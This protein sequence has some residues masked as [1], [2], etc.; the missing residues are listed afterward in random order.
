M[1]DLGPGTEVHEF[2]VADLKK[3]DRTVTPWVLVMHHRPLYCPDMLFDCYS[4]AN[5][6]RASLEDVYVAGGVDVVLNGH[7]HS[8]SRTWPVKDNG[9]HVERSFDSPT[10]PVHITSG[11][12]GNREGI[13]IQWSDPLPKYTAWTLPDSPP[14]TGFGIFDVTPTAMTWSWVDAEADGKVID[15]FTITK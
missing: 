4:R 5:K 10:A 6:M 15:R 2:A 8:A 13:S 14:H 12:A 1:P 3:V 11:A 7:V 9:T